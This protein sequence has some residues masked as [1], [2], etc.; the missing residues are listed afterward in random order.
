MKFLAPGNSAHIRIS[1][2]LLR[3]SPKLLVK[4]LAEFRRGWNYGISGPQILPIP[5]FLAPLQSVAPQHQV[6]DLAE[7]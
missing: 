3:V 1:G 4:D 6:K 5:E 2:P 7:F